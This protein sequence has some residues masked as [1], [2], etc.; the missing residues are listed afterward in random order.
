MTAPSNCRTASSSVSLLGMSKWLVGSSRINNVPCGTMGGLGLRVRAFRVFGLG[1][2]QMVGRLVQDQQRALRHNGWPRS[3]TGKRVF[4]TQSP[5]V[6]LVE[7]VK[8]K[9]NLHVYKNQ[10]LPVKAVQCTKCIPWCT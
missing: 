8:H 7:H 3:E 2:V 10:M 4:V 5:P 6:K 9:R 1:D